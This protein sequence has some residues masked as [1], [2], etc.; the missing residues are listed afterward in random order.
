MLKRR[1][2]LVPASAWIRFEGGAHP[3]ADA[4][5]RSPQRMRQC[6]Q[7]LGRELSGARSI[8]R[9]VGS[10]LLFLRVVFVF[11]PTWF[12]ADPGAG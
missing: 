2:V 9:K 6:S 4:E 3:S 11:L 8:L 1:G 12:I 10:S 5:V 7:P